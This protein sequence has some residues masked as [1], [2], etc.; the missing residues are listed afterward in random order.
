MMH[1]TQTQTQT[2]KPNII[3]LLKLQIKKQ[4]DIQ[5]GEIIQTNSNEPIKQHI[6]REDL[7][8]VE[9]NGITLISYDI[10]EK[11]KIV[12][13]ELVRF[14]NEEKLEKIKPIINQEDE[15]SL[16][17][18]DWTLTN[19][20]KKYCI[21]YQLSNGRIIDVHESYKNY[22]TSYKRNILFDLFRRGKCSKVIYGKKNG[23]KSSSSNYPNNWQEEENDNKLSL[24]SGIK[25]LNSFKCV[26][27][28]ELI[29]YIRKNKEKIEDDMRISLRRSAANKKNS[30]NNKNNKNSKNSKNN[31]RKK[32]QELSTSIY[33]KCMKHYYKTT[34][35][36]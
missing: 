26:L 20:S 9:F 14:Y 17:L 3:N 1:I 12:A 34:I 13:K 15:I 6:N 19:Y 16:R 25:Q 33:K 32:R 2:K 18:I 11:E 28:I 27:E 5:K 8:V 4:D 31:S 29:E 24:I 30:K 36:F 35:T 21:K 23:D 7:F 22:M 10:S